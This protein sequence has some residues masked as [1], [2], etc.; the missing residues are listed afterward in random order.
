[1][2]PALDGKPK[3]WWV[4]ALDIV[5]QPLVLTAIAIVVALVDIISHVPVLLLV[6]ILVLGGIHRSKTFESKSLWRVRIPVYAIILILVSGLCFWLHVLLVRNTSAFVD[7]VVGKIAAEI[8][9]SPKGAGAADAIAQPTP[10]QKRCDALIS[11]SQIFNYIP[12]PNGNKKEPNVELSKC[13]IKYR[14]D[15]LTLFDLFN[16]DFSQPPYTYTSS[17]AMKIS[18]G[19][20][21]KTESLVDYTVVA[22]LSSANRFLSFYIWPTSEVFDVS[23]ALSTKYQ[24]ALTDPW[25]NMKVTGKGA[26]GDSEAASSEDVVFSKRVFIYYE[27]YL[28]L[29]QTLKIENAFKKQGLSVILRGSDYLENE[30]LQAKLARKN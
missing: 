30:K 5:E 13:R 21:P 24:V 12:T 8:N 22:Q 14:P 29:E 19:A 18:T 4:I 7:E 17:Y 11:Q 6:P 9:K 1:M 15:Q 20:S 26:P 2:D 10:D 3:G 27:N 25:A 16:T 23:I 28:T